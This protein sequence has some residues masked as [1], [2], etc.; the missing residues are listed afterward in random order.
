MAVTNRRHLIQPLAV[1]FRHSALTLTLTLTVTFHNLVN[2]FL[3]YLFPK[4]Y[5]KSTNYFL[6][7]HANKQTNKL[8]SK[9]NH[10]Q[11]EYRSE[12]REL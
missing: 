4:F 3:G 8:H 7:Y 6:S 12:T 11:P 10:R 1:Y 9:H 2:S 5:T